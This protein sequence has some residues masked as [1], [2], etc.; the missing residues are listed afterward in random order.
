MLTRKN[1]ITSLALVALTVPASAGSL[2]YVVNGPPSG[3]GQF[4]TI[5]LATGAFK[6]IGPNT[7]EGSTSLVPGP[8]GSL[9]TF[10]FSGNL[11]SINPATGVT[12]RIGPTGLADC[13]APP[14]SPCGP[15][16]ANAFASVGGQL[17]VTDFANKLYR[18]NPGTGA[19]TLIGSTGIP[20]VPFKPLTVNP[21]NTFNAFVEG[22]FSA[23][24]NLYTTFNA[25]TV[26]PKTFTTASVVIPPELYQ[27]DPTTGLATLIGKTDLTL[28]AVA[29]V[30]GTAYAFNIGERE[31]VTLDL[32]NGH[33]SFVSNFDPALGIVSGATAATPEPASLAL[34][35]IGTLAAIFCAWRKRGTRFSSSSLRMTRS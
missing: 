29:E 6:Q 2:V 32:T 35:G 26:D 19:A 17:Y 7:P 31:I 14:A 12:T 10:D 30:N 34:V 4:G 13:S 28:G 3:G 22:M 33:S 23:H 11:D 5:D 18:V 15:H 1:L 24:G 27:I 8:N 21:D 20:E 16:S 9:Y 25:F